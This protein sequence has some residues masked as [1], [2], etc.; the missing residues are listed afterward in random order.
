MEHSR[1]VDLLSEY[2]DGAL[3]ASARTEVERHLASCADCR[4]ELAGDERAARAF[5]RPAQAPS[6][7]ATEA[8]VARVMSR[9]AERAEPLAW[10]SARWLVPALGVGFA[11]LALSFGSTPRGAAVDPASALLVAG[12][13]RG[14]AAS[15]APESPAADA[16]GLGAVD[17]R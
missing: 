11:M 7:F 16:L 13:D 2:R 1:I 10:L 12:M 17:D 9:V 8:F 4:A 15:A 6:P 3:D 14:A 5:F